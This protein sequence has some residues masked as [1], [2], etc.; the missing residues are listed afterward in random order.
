MEERTGHERQAIELIDWYVIENSPTRIE[1]GLVYNDPVEVSSSID[2]PDKLLIQVELSEFKTKK[3]GLKLT[4]SV[5]LSKEI[6][7]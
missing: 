2:G 4:P 7:Q 1:L 5:L 3:A 6:P